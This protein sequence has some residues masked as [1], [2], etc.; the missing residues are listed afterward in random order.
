MA[1]VFG[2]EPFAL[3][4]VAPL[5]GALRYEVG[6]V[7]LQAAY[8]RLSSREPCRPSTVTPPPAS[9]V[10][11]RLSSPLRIFQTVSLPPPC[12]PLHSPTMNLPLDRYI[13][14]MYI[15]PMAVEFDPK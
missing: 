1:P 7:A 3:Q 9:A 8:R 12:T 2:V 14:Y 15:S 11:Q 10:V 6:G 4:G 13:S 5:G